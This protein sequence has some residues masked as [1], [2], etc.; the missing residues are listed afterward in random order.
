MPALPNRGVSQLSQGL[1]QSQIIQEKF[2][3]LIG[4]CNWLNDNDFSI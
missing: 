2:I 3:Y 1:A 4:I